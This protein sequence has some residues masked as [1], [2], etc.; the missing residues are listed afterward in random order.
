M[1]D[2]QA[3]ASAN[4]PPLHSDDVEIEHP[5][6]PAPPAAAAEV[7]LDGLERLQHVG[8]IERA[9]D[10]RD[11]IGEVAARAAVRGLST[12]G[13]GVEQRRNRGRAARSPPTT[14]PAGRPKRPWRPVRANADG[15]EVD[16]SAN[17]I[18]SS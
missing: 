13:D 17:T 3:R 18:R 5:R 8:R 4:R 12:I 16:I 2:G 1:R 11:R 9:F 7:A 10:Q 6:A 15:V 14:T